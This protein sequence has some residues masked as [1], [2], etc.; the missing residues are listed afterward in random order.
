[1][2]LVQVSKQPKRPRVLTESAKSH[3]GSSGR[4]SQKS[5][6]HRPNAVSHQRTLPE[7][8]FAHCKRLFWE[9]HSRGPNTPFAPSLS[10]FG[11]FGC[12][13][14]CTRAAESQ[15]L[16][17]FLS[18]FG[19]FLADPQKT[20]QGS[21]CRTSLWS[22][23]LNFRQFCCTNVWEFWAEVFA[24]VLFAP[25]VP[26][27]QARKLRPKLRPELPPSKTQTS[28]KT[29]LCRNPL[30]GPLAD[31]FKNPSETPFRNPSETLGVL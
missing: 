24:E 8:G 22:F 2:A 31:P 4:E 11:H 6:S 27:K 18:I 13:D 7:K 9:S 15:N 23:S 19:D 28:P 10:T 5:L 16:G 1:M 17:V 25:T 29:S 14:S 30:P 3:L 20:W 21:P 12:F 26:A